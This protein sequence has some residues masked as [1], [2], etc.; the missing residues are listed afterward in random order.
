MAAMKG[1][2]TVLF[3][4]HILSDVQEVCD[5]VAVLNHG[6]VLFQGPLNEL[7][8]GKAIPSITVRLAA[9]EPATNALLREQPWVRQ[10]IE[11]QPGVLVI[12]TR[13]TAEAQDH[14]IPILAQAN[15]KVIS[16]TPQEVTLED[17]FLELTT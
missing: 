14:L 8:V 16:I 3:S 10:V 15:C 7:L 1:D 13:S 4:S 11:V 6:K 2:A 9:P 5:R 12:D 17:A